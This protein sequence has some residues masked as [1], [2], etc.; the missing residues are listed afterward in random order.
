MQG[1]ETVGM[2]RVFLT[3]RRSFGVSGNLAV[4]LSLLLC[5]MYKTDGKYGTA[6][7]A[8]QIPLGYVG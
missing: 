3:G 1:G 8:W 2:R 7:R 4:F 6:V 5:A